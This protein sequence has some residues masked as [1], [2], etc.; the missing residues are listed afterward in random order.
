MDP[1]LKAKMVQ[2]VQRYF[3]EFLENFKEKNEDGSRQED[4]YY[5]EQAKAMIR[6]N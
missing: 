4:F 6:E 2:R 1:Q 5:I 3:L